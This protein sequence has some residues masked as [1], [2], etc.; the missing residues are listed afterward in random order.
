MKKIFALLLAVGVFATTSFA[1]TKPAA[2]KTPAPVKKEAVKPAEKPKVVT[3]TTAPTKKDGTPDKR[4]KE[5]KAT[6][7]PTGPT[8]KDGTPDKR[9]KENKKG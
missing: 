8:K 4:F 6:A 3:T 5:N 9:Y 2:A 1:Q 7:K